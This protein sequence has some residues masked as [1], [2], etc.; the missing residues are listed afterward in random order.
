M[1]PLKDIYN[2]AYVQKLTADI[3]SVNLEFDAEACSRLILQPDW[4]ALELMERKRRITEALH[5]TLPASY[6][7]ALK[8][9]VQVAPSYSGLAGIVFPDFVQC[10][11]LEFWEESID[12]LEILTE[13]STAEFAVRPYFIQDTER[14]ISQSEIW[15]ESSNEHVRRLASEGSRPR[16]P[17]G[18]SVPTFKQDP[19][20]ILPILEKL[21]EDESLYVRRSVANSLNDITKTHPDLFIEIANNWYG[22]SV[23]T[24]WIIKHASRSLLKKG[25]KQV[26]ALFGYENSHNLHI[27][28]FEFKTASIKV[29]ERVDFSFDLYS[30][31]GTKLRVDYAI[32]YVKARGNRTR[33]VFKLSE[34]SIQKNETKSYS[35]THAFEDLSTRKHHPGLHQLTIIVNGEEKVSVEFEVG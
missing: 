13:Y 25:D 26:L 5:E 8:I 32:D 29:G 33:K 9:L 2:E 16:L 10:Y 27:Q 12:A 18:I 6:P 14:M 19:T 23:D 24:D 35:R 34:T 28:E 30:E 4:Q 1:E 22:E 11:G 15:A 31:V 17:W 20:P 21:K 3:K 7:E